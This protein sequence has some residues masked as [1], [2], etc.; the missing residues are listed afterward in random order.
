[1]QN[2]TLDRL[3]NGEIG[4]RQAY[5]LLY[6]KPARVRKPRKAHFAV[7]RIRIPEEKG[8]NALLAVLFALP[9]P[10]GFARL[11]LKR[12]DIDHETIPM[13]RDEL[14]KLVSVRGL[15]VDVRTKDGVKVFIKTI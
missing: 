5:R 9:V 3:Q 10:I 12:A 14:L 4:K 2:Q 15:K 6:P 7:V 13:E 1:M 11:L 8:A